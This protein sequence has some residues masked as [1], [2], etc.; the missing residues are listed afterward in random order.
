MGCWGLSPLCGEAPAK[1]SR[2][3]TQGSQPEERCFADTGGGKSRSAPHPLALCARFA[4]EVATAET[5]S[6]VTSVPPSC[7]SLLLTLSELSLLNWAGGDACE[8]VL[9]GLWCKGLA[10]CG[11]W[12]IAGPWPSARFTPWRKS[13]LRFRVARWILL[14]ERRSRAPTPIAHPGASNPTDPCHPWAWTTCSPPGTTAAGAAGS[15]QTFVPPWHL[16]PQDAKSGHP[17]CFALAVA[18][19]EYLGPF[20]SAFAFYM[21]LPYLSVTDHCTSWLAYT[22]MEYKRASPKL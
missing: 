7:P 9:S 13:V 12:T 11:C 19:A 3:L 6:R 17:S 4:L 22:W 10:D 8:T 20:C 1:P 14:E 16:P 21:H 15:H 5:P 2:C 18:L